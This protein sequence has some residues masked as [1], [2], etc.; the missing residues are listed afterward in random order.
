MRSQ[1]FIQSHRVLAF[2]LGV[3]A[4]AG[5]ACSNA[6]EGESKNAYPFI[7]QE[8]GNSPDHYICAG[9]AGAVE[10]LGEGTEI[11]GLESSEALAARLWD[12]LAGPDED[13][14]LKYFT[15]LGLRDGTE[16]PV[17]SKA[18][19]EEIGLLIQEKCESAAKK[20]WQKEMSHPDPRTPKGRSL[21]KN[22]QEYSELVYGKHLDKITNEDQLRELINEDEDGVVA[23]GAW[24]QR[25]F[26]E[27]VP[28]N[29]VERK[30]LQVDPRTG[31]YPA[32]VTSAHSFLITYDENQDQLFVYDSDDPDG[33]WPM[34][35][36]GK[37][38]C[39]VAGRARHQCNGFR[40][41]W[42]IDDHM[43]HGP[44]HQT[45]CNILPL[46]DFLRRLRSLAD[47]DEDDRDDGS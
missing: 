46:K 44:T 20:I 35:V 39:P 41:T 10:C 43:G 47:G 9:L 21:L 12:E 14:G 32:T 25:F 38:F 28:L 11:E 7:A 45:Y 36:E 16:V 26:Y 19:I 8:A 42:R 29:I 4:L 22:R 18:A 30:N 23:V 31:D 3:S 5:N 37:G 40:I 1:R 34:C 17:C 33:K 15:H 27:G 24:G 6:G 13:G 2:A